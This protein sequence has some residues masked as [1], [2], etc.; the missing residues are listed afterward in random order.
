MGCSDSYQIETEGNLQFECWCG[1]V[2]YTM[3]ETV[4]RLQLYCCCRDCAENAEC[5]A[6]LGNTQMNMETIQGPCTTVIVANS[7]REVRG[8]ENIRIYKRRADCADQLHIA[9]CCKAMIGVNHPGPGPHCVPMQ[10]G[11]CNVKC[12]GAVIGKEACTHRTFTDDWLPKNDP[13]SLPL[14][15]FQGTDCPK[16]RNVVTSGF[17]FTFK[18]RTK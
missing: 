16:M 5:S 11:A 10:G 12:D 1:K 3:R 9:T 2:C 6:Y 13:T 18:A 8:I 7:V 14:P 15:S 17:V 4:P